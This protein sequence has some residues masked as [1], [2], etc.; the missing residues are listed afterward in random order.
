MSKITLASIQETIA[1]DG[2]SIVSPV[3]VNLDTPME[4]K[5]A[6][7]HLVVAPYKKIRTRRECP[8]CAQNHF[9]KMDSAPVP[10]KTKTACR[11][12]ALDQA[13]HITGYSLFDDQVLI[14]YGT[15]EAHEQNE[16]DRL[17]EVNMWLISQIK[18]FSPDIVGI[19][20]IQYQPDAG[21]ITFQTLARLQ[22][23]LAETCI[24][25][26]LIFKICPTN[27]WRAHCGVKG[28]SRSDRKKSMQSL[29]K[30]W[31]DISV[32]DDEADAIGIGKYL[33]DTHKVQTIVNWE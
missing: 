16:F 24:Q 28:R 12:L 15:Y 31:F 11:I 2:W 18:N 1:P 17:H 5:C 20:G 25:A 26:N 19:E 6:E 10:R 27:T 4:F 22:G 14:K 7:G 8:V 30:Q 29:V 23:I 9:K 13:S 21:V 3:Y 33:A 32:S